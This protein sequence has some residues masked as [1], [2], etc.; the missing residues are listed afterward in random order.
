MT[1]LENSVEKAYDRYVTA[2]EKLEQHL[3]KRFIDGLEFTVEYNNDGVCIC[4][5]DEKKGPVVVPVSS[6]PD[7]KLSLDV[8]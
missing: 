1:N 4:F 8:V 2:C 5:E 6:L 7:G 3:R